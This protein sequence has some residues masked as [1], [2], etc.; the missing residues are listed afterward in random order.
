MKRRL[1]GLLGGLLA[2]DACHA[3]G[4]AGSGW[5]HPLTGVDHMLAMVAVGGWS[6]QL[7]GRALYVVPAAFVGAMSVGAALVFTRI[8]LPG[9]ELAIALSVLLLGSAIALGG[10]FPLALAAAGTG[11]FG[12]CHGYAHGAEVP[13]TQGQWTYAA[14]FLITT[15]GLHVAGLT[16]G[17][18]LLDHP[19][20]R[21]WLRVSGAATAMTGIYLSVNRLLEAAV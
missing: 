11:L 5:L 16:G 9:I 6:A 3:H 13:G 7:G 15:A 2:S 10:R 19:D 21:R 1:P 18:L 8:P 4:F 12:V 20:G 17:L 14:G